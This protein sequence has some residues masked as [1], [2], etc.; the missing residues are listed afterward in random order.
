M[1]GFLAED[2][3]KQ[4]ATRC[5]RVG[6]LI[7]ER[8]AYSLVQMAEYQGDGVVFF[9]FGLIL[10]DQADI[11]LDTH[12]LVFGQQECLALTDMAGVEG[13]DLPTLLG[14]MHGIAAFPFARQKQTT[15]LQPVDHLFEKLIGFLAEE[16][17]VRAVP[18]IPDG[19]VEN[20]SG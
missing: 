16:K 13:I 2:F 11:I 8:L 14:R 12:I 6:K 7:E 9:G 17:I 19:H 4:G 18:F 1:T 15:G 20:L 3:H 5:Q 10:L